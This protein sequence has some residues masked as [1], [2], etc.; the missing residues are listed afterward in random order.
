MSVNGSTA[1]P[2]NDANATILAASAAIIAANATRANSTEGANAAA[3]ATFPGG[4]EATAHP[5]I[6]SAF[7]L[8]QKRNS[9]S[10]LDRV[11]AN[12][13]LG[14]LEK[15]GELLVPSPRLSRNPDAKASSGSGPNTPRK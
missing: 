8:G 9:L 5:A 2:N 15:S 4:T 14:H 11:R 7:K 10:S 13:V 6:V 1:T 12:G 3:D